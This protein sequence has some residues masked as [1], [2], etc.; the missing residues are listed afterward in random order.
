[1]CSS[2]LETGGVFWDICGGNWDGLYTQLAEKSW[3]FGTAPMRIDL[4]EDPAVNTLE[5]RADSDLLS[6]W[7]WDGEA[8]LLDG[9]TE[10]LELWQPVQVSYELAQDCQ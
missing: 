9:D 2:D 5:L 1:M 6:A 8:I 3:G 10:G 7:T 4:A